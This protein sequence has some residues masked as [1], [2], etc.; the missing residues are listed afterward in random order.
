[1]LLVLLFCGTTLNNVQGSSTP[2]ENVWL[3]TTVEVLILNIL[4]LL[5]CTL[6]WP[7]PNTEGESSRRF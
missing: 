5:I 3:I 1:M 2:T 6:G 7:S 4:L